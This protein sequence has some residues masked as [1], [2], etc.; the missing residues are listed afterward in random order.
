[1]DAL[2]IG[3]LVMIAL[4]GVWSMLLFVSTVKM[5][6]QVKAMRS[7]ARKGDRWQMFGLLGLAVASFGVLLFDIGF[8]KEH[9]GTSAAVVAGI[10]FALFYLHQKQRFH[11]DRVKALFKK[12]P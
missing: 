1:M 6:N 9:P 4:I 3:L 7:F 2:Q 8:V 11:C 5:M 12:Q 10:L